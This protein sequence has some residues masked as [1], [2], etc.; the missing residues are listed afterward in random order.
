MNSIV[1]THV[2]DKTSFSYANSPEFKAILEEIRIDAEQRRQAGGQAPFAIIEKLKTHK[3]GAL[4]VPVEYGGKG[5]TITELFKIIIEISHFDSDVAQILR[6]HY[7]FIEETL[8]SN[9]PEFQHKW[10]TIAGQ[11]FIT[12]NAVTEISNNTV[13]NGQYATKIIKNGSA[14][15][16][17]GKKYFTTGTLYAD[18]VVVRV[19]SETGKAFNLILPKNREG[20]TVIDDWDGIGQKYTASGTTKFENVDVFEE[21]IVHVPVEQVSFKPFTQLYLHAIIA[22]ILKAV[23]T[24]SSILLRKRNRSFSY[25]TTESAADD[26][27][28]LEKIGEISSNTFIVES[29][30]LQA[31][32]FQDVAF[33]STVDG[34]TNFEL[35][36]EAALAA[37]KVKIAIEP[38]ALKTATQLFDVTGASST[39]RALNLDRHWLNIRTLC[40]HNPA[41]FKAAAIGNLLVNNVKLPNNPYF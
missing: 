40:S 1:K 39:R 11:G 2:A 34:V 35:A 19:G 23:E 36:H 22:G 41:S 10:L 17:S 13:G 6:S 16:L 32:Q 28:L 25:G 30:I 4:R 12:G 7:Q 31:A 9:Q 33:N 26:P 21:E 29:A 24:E 15:K 20:I 5:I 38:I 18:Y 3:I 8:R 27:L 37:S 14:Y